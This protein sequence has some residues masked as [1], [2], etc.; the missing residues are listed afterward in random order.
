MTHDIAYIDNSKKDLLYF[1]VW[2][3]KFKIVETK[4]PFSNSTL[5]IV[6]SGN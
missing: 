3:Q 6:N 1:K 2:K 5:T 4:P